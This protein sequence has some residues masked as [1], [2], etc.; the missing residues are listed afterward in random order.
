MFQVLFSANAQGVLLFKE[1]ALQ[2]TGRCVQARTP[3]EMLTEMDDPMVWE[4]VLAARA[5]EKQE[6]VSKTVVFENSIVDSPASGVKE[7]TE[8]GQ[9]HVQLLQYG[10]D[11]R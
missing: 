1:A 9:A 6:A 4:S 2:P 8:Q 3:S 5:R 7:V 10:M 11:M